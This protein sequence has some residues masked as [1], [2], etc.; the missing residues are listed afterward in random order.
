MRA[1]LSTE[2]EAS[3]EDCHYTVLTTLMWVAAKS[4]IIFWNTVFS[5]WFVHLLY[6]CSQKE[7]ESCENIR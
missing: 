4:I 3:G 6:L 7:V 1:N 2:Q 5:L